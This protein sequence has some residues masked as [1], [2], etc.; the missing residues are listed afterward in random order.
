[1]NVIS[2]VVDFSETSKKAV[3]YAVWLAKT[4]NAS[5]HLVHFASNSRDLESLEEKLVA[6]SEINLANVSFTCSIHAGEYLKELPKI[7]KNQNSDLVV[8]G[9]RKTQSPS[10]LSTAGNIIKLIKLLPLPT[11]VINENL[12][13]PEAPIKEILFPMAPHDNFT[14]KIEETARW[15][16]LHGARV[17]LF[18]LVSKDQALPEAISKNLEKS[19]KHLKDQNIEY[20]ETQKDTEVYS[21]GY[22]KDILRYAEEMNF[23]LIS[24]MSQNSEENLYFGDMEKSVLIQNALGIPVLCVNR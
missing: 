8:M 5:I 23:D 4:Y 18:S 1:M 10:E 9:T 21:V 24:I 16:K 13:H 17:H 12:V 2:C 3:A 19:M 6:H 15:A 22:A 20:I 7:I 14:I 11:V